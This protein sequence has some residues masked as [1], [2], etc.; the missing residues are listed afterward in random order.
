MKKNLFGAVI[1][2]LSAFLTAGSAWIFPACGPK[3]DGSWMR[4]HWS[5]QA[6]IG[7]GIVLVI[8][9]IAYLILS[10]RSVKAVLSLAIVPVGLL[11]IAVPQGLI[12][13]CG[14]PGMQCRAVFQPAVTII[15]IVIVLLAAVNAFLLLKAERKRV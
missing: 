2:A 13:L 10:Q 6:V 15:S 12:G 5:Q 9:S 11:A 14:M 1:L 8:L 3:S 7:I 4:C